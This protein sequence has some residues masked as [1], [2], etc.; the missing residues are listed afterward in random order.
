MPGFPHLYQFVEQLDRFVS[1]LDTRTVVATLLAV[2]FVWVVFRMFLLVY[3]TLRCGLGK[4]DFL[5]LGKVLKKHQTKL[6]KFSNVV[7]LAVG[8]KIRKGKKV[9]RRSINVLVSKKEDMDRLAPEDRIPRTVDGIST[10]VIV[11]GP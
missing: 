3:R 11:V 4:P 2:I 5:T 10:D 1:R 9:N 8:D 7:G 6:M